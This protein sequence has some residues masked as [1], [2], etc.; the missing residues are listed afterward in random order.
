M[1][2][3]CYGK[4]Q[5]HGVKHNVLRLYEDIQSALQYDRNK[6]IWNRVNMWYFLEKTGFSPSAYLNTENERDAKLIK[7]KNKDITDD[8]LNFA[9]YLR[10]TNL[11][12]YFI[13]C[14][15]IYDEYGMMGI[16]AQLE[17]AWNLDPALLFL[18]SKKYEVI[19]GY[20]SFEPGCAF[21]TKGAYGFLPLP[22]EQFILNGYTEWKEGDNYE[23]ESVEQRFNNRTDAENAEKQF[24]ESNSDSEELWTG[25]IPIDVDRVPPGI[26]GMYYED[27]NCIPGMIYDI[28][29]K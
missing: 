2:N 25:I 15:I 23:Y 21:A 9:T 29:I 8:S 13:D 17:S 6:K 24:R 22:E 7:D 3:W 12:A 19:Y 4:I 27:I 14:D 16:E 10:Q 11:R 20:T 1:P 5:F 18:I 28:E 26:L